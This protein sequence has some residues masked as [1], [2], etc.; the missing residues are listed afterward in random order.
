[1]EDIDIASEYSKDERSQGKKK[2]VRRP[3]PAF[4]GS[5]R[6]GEYYFQIILLLLPEGKWRASLS[7]LSHLFKVNPTVQGLCPAN[8][9]RGL[10][11]VYKG[12]GVLT[13]SLG[14]Y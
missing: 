6:S 7:S 1:M 12:E 13:E 14:P 11:Y 8:Y 10:A 4:R 9:V 2:T 3:N 5:S